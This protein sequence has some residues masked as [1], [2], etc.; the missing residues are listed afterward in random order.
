MSFVDML[1]NSTFD[2][3]NLTEFP[4]S[5]QLLPSSLWAILLGRI[6]QAGI[7]EKWCTC[8]EPYDPKP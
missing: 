7:T 3:M 4:V 5:T 2:Y 8:N 1:E 6:W